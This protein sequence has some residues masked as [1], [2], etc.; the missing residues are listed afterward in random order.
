[1]RIYLTLSVSASSGH[2]DFMFKHI[3]YDTLKSLGHD[4]IFYPYHEANR[5]GES[6]IIDIKLISENIFNDFL[7][8]HKQKPFDFFISYY[9]SL[10]VTP[11]LFKR[12]REKVFC[13]NYTTNFHQIENYSSIIPEV[14]LSIFASKEAEAYFI[15]RSLPSYYMPFAGL[16]RNLSYTPEKDG[17][18]SFVGTSYGPRVNY[19]WRCF[20][21]E[22]PLE[23][24]GTNWIKNHHNRA[25][26][27]IIKLL[28]QLVIGNKLSIDTAYR[29]LNDILLDELN[30][31]YKQKLHEPLSDEQYS[32]TLSHS[33]IVLNIPESRFGH[34]YSNHRVLI[35]ANLRD[36]EVP[37]AGSLLL[38]QDNQEIRSFFEEGKEMITY[39]N[40]YELI[41]KVR[42]Y[43]S[44]P[45]K[46]VDISLA[47]HERVKK[48]HLW[49]HRFEKLISHLKK[50]Y[51]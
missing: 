43:L 48:E 46:I 39:N 35:G 50:N 25:V 10:K 38:T 49:E 15:S 12:V 11:E 19:I 2:N 14:N 27:R 33:S 5:V 40:E 47:G 23:V 4:V 3:F 37:T 7:K 24:Y 26:L 34:N 13:V 1:M 18:I 28:S 30:L 17:R 8:H 9:S 41:D 16:S 51:L 6:A 32:N 22:L 44:N 21:N 31:N 29:G 42:Y 45:S 20:Q 36:F